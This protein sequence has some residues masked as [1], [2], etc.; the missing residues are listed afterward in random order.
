MIDVE[1]LLTDLGV[2][3][4]NG[5]VHNLKTFCINP[6]HQ[7]TYP[8][9][10]VH[11]ETGILHC[12]GCHLRGNLFTLL[13]YKG[14]H[15]ANAILYLQKFAR[16]GYTEEEVR[17]AL[18]EFIKDRGEVESDTV[19]YTNVELPMHRVIESNFYL[20][21]RGITKED[22]KK[23]SIAVISQ[24]R[25]IGWILI[26]IYQ[27]GILRTYFMRNSF[28]DGKLYGTYQRNDILAGLDFVE[29]TDIVYVTEGIFDSMAVSRA[30]FPA[31][32]C[33]SN[34]LLP[35]QLDHLKLFSKVVLIPDND[36]RG[37]D[38]IRSAGPLIHS[39]D[40]RVCELPSHRKDAAECTTEEIQSSM[41]HEFFWNEFM[42]N[43]YFLK[44]TS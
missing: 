28:G 4:R 25:N 16:G 3:Y 2:E 18:E 35:E 33:L 7:E 37:I 27:G 29:N 10:Y 39:I 42:I 19:K 31:V 15:G 41:K 11:R 6:D 23:W 12:F 14:I 38:L 21:K 34:Y 9:M 8:S 43:K 5:G 1:R 36:I 13:H 30:G 24:G 44:K 40:V 26:P 32:A 17:K 22:I 20:E